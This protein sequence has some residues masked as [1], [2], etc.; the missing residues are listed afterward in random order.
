MGV[1]PGLAD[2]DAA[3]LGVAELHVAAADDSSLEFGFQVRGEATV[4]VEVDVDVRERDEAEWGRGCL[5]E[6][7]A[8]GEEAGVGVDPIHQILPWWETTSSKTQ[9]LSRGHLIVLVW[10]G[11][12]S[13]SVR[14]LRVLDQ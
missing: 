11:E 12:A 1:A 13:Y 8:A 9:Y 4:L 2:L 14:Q 6:G 10:S 3:E 5:A 7:F